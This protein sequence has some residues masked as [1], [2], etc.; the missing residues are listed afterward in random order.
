MIYILKS[1]VLVIGLPVRA[2]P[3]QE[4][5]HIYVK[6]ARRIQ[7]IKYIIDDN[8]YQSIPIDLINPLMLIIDDQSMTKIRVVIDWYR[9]S[10]A[11]D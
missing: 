7:S 10:I 1:I 6:K 9:F 4:M 11:I 8:R 5:S 3:Y 2:T